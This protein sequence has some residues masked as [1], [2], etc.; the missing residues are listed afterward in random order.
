L[1]GLNHLLTKTAVHQ[2]N[3]DFFVN[4]QMDYGSSVIGIDQHEGPLTIHSF[5]FLGVP[6]NGV[7]CAIIYEIN[8]LRHKKVL[9]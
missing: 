9:K 7:K 3:S 4:G 2:E 8:W 5:P 6:K 1:R